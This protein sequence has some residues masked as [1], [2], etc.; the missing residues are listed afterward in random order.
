MIVSAVRE[1]LSLSLTAFRDK[2][3]HAAVEVEPLEQVVDFLQEQLKKQHISRLR[4]NECTIELGF[5]LSD[6]LT[7]LERVSDHCSNIAGCILEITH[8][9]M[10]IHEYLRKVK[11]GQMQEFN[12][13]YDQYKE[14]YS[15]P[16]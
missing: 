3:L 10:E 5:V 2:D 16:E 13:L 4:R 7:N 9:N 14:K 12:D 1:I 11:G 15:L 8:D 6:I